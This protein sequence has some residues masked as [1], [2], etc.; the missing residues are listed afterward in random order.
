MPD[1]ARDDERWRSEGKGIGEAI[2]LS[3]EW[4]LLVGPA[5]IITIMK[6]QNIEPK[7]KQQSQASGGSEREREDSAVQQHGPT[8]AEWESV[9]TN[10]NIVIPMSVAHA[11]S[12]E[13]RA[14]HS[15]DSSRMRAGT[16]CGVQIAFPH[17]SSS[18]HALRWPTQPF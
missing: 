17:T 13:A 7:G 2:I 12:S 8:A 15:S 1:D 3:S 9:I 18:C 14:D 5:I 4:V 10:L 11:V 16:G 6:E